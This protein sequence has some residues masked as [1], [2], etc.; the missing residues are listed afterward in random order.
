MRVWGSWNVRHAASLELELRRDETPISGRQ[1][2]RLFDVDSVVARL[3][4]DTHARQRNNPLEKET[5]YRSQKDALIP[6]RMTTALTLSLNTKVDF[7][8]WKRAHNFYDFETLTPIK[9]KG[10]VD[11]VPVFRPLGQA[12]KDDSNRVRIF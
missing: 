4:C 12:L 9:A 7:E 1:A 10:Y 3:L 6:K 2:P 8:V 5:D 11:P